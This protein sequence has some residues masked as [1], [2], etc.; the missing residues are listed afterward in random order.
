VDLERAISK[1]KTQPEIGAIV[2]VQRVGSEPVTLPAREGVSK[3]SSRG[4]FAAPAGLSRKSHSSPMRSG[5][6]AATASATQRFGHAARAARASERLHHL[7]VAEKF[8]EQSIQDP[9]D[10]ALFVERVKAVM[11]LSVRRSV[12]T[13]PQPRGIAA[14]RREDPTR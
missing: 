8:A 5:A 14:P 7:R 3:T 13:E 6:R 12:P 9:R 2:G 10:R 4:H 1:S 11:D